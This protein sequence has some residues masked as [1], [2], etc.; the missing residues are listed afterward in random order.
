VNE[1]FDGMADG[2]VADLSRRTMFVGNAVVIYTHDMHPGH[3]EVLEAFK[4]NYEG[5]KHLMLVEKSSDLVASVVEPVWKK[6][7]REKV[8]PL[9]DGSVRINNSA[10]GLCLHFSEGFLMGDG[11]ADQVADM[12]WEEIAEKTTCYFRVIVIPRDGKGVS[13]EGKGEGPITEHECLRVVRI[14][15]EEMDSEQMVEAIDAIRTTN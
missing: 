14:L 11:M 2:L 6:S 7:L 15:S 12:V 9:T 8:A 5:E 1:L 10:V 13:V 4:D 3:K